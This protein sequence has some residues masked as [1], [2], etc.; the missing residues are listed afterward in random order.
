MFLLYAGMVYAIDVNKG[1]L[2]I[3]REAAK[4]QDLDGVITAIH[5]DLRSYSVGCETS[6]TFCMKLCIS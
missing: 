3:L 5:S 1:R 4:L 2:R 6:L